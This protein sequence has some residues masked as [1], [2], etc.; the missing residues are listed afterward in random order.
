LEGWRRGP[1]PDEFL[2]RGGERG[3]Q[4]RSPHRAKAKV[5]K[6]FPGR[7]SSA[8]DA[9]TPPRTR[10][11]PTQP[12]LKFPPDL[13]TNSHPSPIPNESVPLYGRRLL[14]PGVS[15]SNNRS[16]RHRLPGHSLVRAAL[17][18]PGRQHEHQPLRSPSTA[19][20]VP[21]TG[22]ACSARA[23]AR[24]TTAPFAIDCPAAPLYGR[25]LLR[26]GVSTSNNCSVRH[27]LPA[28]SRY[29]PFKSAFK[30]TWLPFKT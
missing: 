8:A 1:A 7:F 2:L 3:R 11:S 9:S 25:R 29:S 6:N 28:R 15:T 12:P 27:R 16:V 14:R 30:L 19:R 20:P 13:P 23:S 5:L 18:P 4:P 26:P 22:G 10:Q 21:C 17:A 24:A